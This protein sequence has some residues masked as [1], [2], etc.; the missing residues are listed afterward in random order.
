MNILEKFKK[1]SN[2]DKKHFSIYCI[3]NDIYSSA[4]SNNFDISDEYAMKIQEKIISI[5]F[6]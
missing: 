3:Y 6:G 1:L 5:V 2:E 4:K